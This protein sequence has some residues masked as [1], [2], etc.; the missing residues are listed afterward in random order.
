M[1]LLFSSE[2]YDNMI[3]CDGS[4]CHVF[5]LPKITAR[6]RLVLFQF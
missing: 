6:W 5:T 4:D 2:M 1:V 3:G